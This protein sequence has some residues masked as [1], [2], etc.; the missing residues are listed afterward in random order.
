MEEIEEERFM[1]LNGIPDEDD[2]FLNNGI[3]PEIED[4]EEEFLSN[5][6]GFS[7]K[8]SVFGITG[9]LS[10]L[11]STS[12]PREDCLNITFLT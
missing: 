11:T 10:R 5:D 12:F 6:G 1:L 7:E 4:E 8:V 9:V 3:F 2:R